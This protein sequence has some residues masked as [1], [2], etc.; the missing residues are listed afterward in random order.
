L[1]ANLPSSDGEIHP[2]PEQQQELNALY[3]R[4]FGIGSKPNKSAAPVPPISSFSPTPEQTAQIADPHQQHV[5]IAPFGED[6]AA[7]VPPQPFFK[8]RGALECC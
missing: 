8:F 7:P 4:Q 1:T 3:R 5:M 2:T 6:G